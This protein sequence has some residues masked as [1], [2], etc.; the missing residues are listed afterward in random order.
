MPPHSKTWRQFGWFSTL[1]LF[2]AGCATYHPQPISPAKT[3]A[4]FD[5]RSLDEPG[6]RAFLE[7]NHVAAPSPGDAWNLKQLTLA[8]FYYQPTLAEARA[9]LLAAQAARVTAG[10]RPNP[11]LTV[12]PGYDSGIPDNPSPWLVPVSVDWPIETAGKRGY[13]MA[14]ARHLTEA[15]RWNLVGAVWQ[16]RSGVRAALLNLYAARQ[17]ESLLARQETAQSNV[18]RLLEGQLA[19]GSVSSYEV[20]QARIMLDTTRLAW[21]QAV[22]QSRQ[23]RVQLAAALGVPRRALDGVRLSFADFNRF[24]RRLTRPEVRRQALLDR[25][26]M[27][28]ALADYAASQ[29]AL[30]LEIANQYPDLHLG[31]GYAWNAGSAGDSEWDLGLT[32]TL[33]ILNQNQGPIAEAEAN[34]KVAGAHFLAVQSQAIGQID[35]AL[36]GYQAAIQQVATAAALLKNLRRRLDSIHAQVRAGE[37]EPLTAASAEVEYDAGAESRLNTMVQAQ[38]AL[39]RLEDA[40]QSPLTL[41]PA[42]LDA[43][44]NNTNA[45]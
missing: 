36:A 22:G 9:Q 3:A 39:G 20:T 21:Q 42:T 23:A 30:Q 17:T 5:A 8:A 6:L 16:V 12:T 19:A 18:V 32:L 33:P 4:A 38:Q 26:D 35:G 37:M 31:P 13:R 45:K 44:Q 40:V 25:A 41:P 2:I 14:Q 29:A 1:L 43:A 7:S 15:A 34:R 28:S 27:R 10:E 24:P 11:S